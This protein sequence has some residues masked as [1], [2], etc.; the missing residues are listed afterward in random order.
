MKRLLLVLSLLATPAMASD[1][2]SSYSE[3]V[4]ESISWTGVSVGVH[5]AYAMVDHDVEGV[6]FST[7]GFGAGVNINAD[8][9]PF[10]G[11]LVVGLLGQYTWSDNSEVVQGATVTSGDSFLLGARV[12]VLLNK[13]TLLYALGGWGQHTVNYSA[14]MEDQSLKFGVDYDNLVVGAGIEHA[15][16]KLRVGAE[17]QYWTGD[18]KLEA[19]GDLSSEI[20]QHR[21]L[22]SAKYAF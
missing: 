14:T 8:Y 5:G 16:G 9:Q 1:L 21:M 13:P 4:K 18:D 12:G 11:N 20:D 22:I 3:P 19:A 17:Y 6:E 10:G 7:D 2:R 15:I